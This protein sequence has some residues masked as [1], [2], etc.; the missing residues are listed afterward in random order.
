[1]R[2]LLVGEAPKVEIPGTTEI[3]TELKTMN[4][5]NWRNIRDELLAR[6]PAK[7]DEV[8]AGAIKTEAILA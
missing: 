3:R 6:L 1:M 5:E 7:Q 8:T 2:A 4:A